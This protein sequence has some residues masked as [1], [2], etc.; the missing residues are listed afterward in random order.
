MEKIMNIDSK[1][2]VPYSH[3]PFFVALYDAI[4]LFNLNITINDILAG[5]STGDDVSVTGSD[6]FNWCEE[7]KNTSST[8]KCNY[9]SGDVIVCLLHYM[10]KI[11]SRD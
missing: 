10:K 2:I 9:E 7:I 4:Q 5:F 1:V 8:T 3:C 6:L 11:E